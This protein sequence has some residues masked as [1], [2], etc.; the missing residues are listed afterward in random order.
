MG[1][2][3]QAQAKQVV[4][5]A[6]FVDEFLPFAGDVAVQEAEQGTVDVHGVGPA[7]AGPG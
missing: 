3:M 1:Q 4:G 5:L 2:A 7:E 6:G